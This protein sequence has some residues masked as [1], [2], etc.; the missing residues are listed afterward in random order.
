VRAEHFARAAMML[1]HAF[2]IVAG[3]MVDAD[4]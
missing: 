3:A 1:R 4:R 2:V